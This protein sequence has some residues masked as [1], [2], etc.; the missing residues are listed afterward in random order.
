MENYDI[1]LEKEFAVSVAEYYNTWVGIV[2]IFCRRDKDH[3]LYKIGKFFFRKFDFPTEVGDKGRIF[4]EFSRISFICDYEIHSENKASCQIYTAKRDM[5]LAVDCNLI[6]TDNGVR[7]EYALN[8][9]KLPRMKRFFINQSVKFLV[10][11]TLD[12]IA[13]EAQKLEVPE[14]QVSTGLMAG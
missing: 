2:E 8:Y 5:H 7:V 3:H 10:P 13:R 1:Y 4:F 9:I 6:P 14:V 11:K 12:I